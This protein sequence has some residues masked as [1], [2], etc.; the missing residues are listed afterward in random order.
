M[1]SVLDITIQLFKVIS[2]DIDTNDYNIIY[3]EL[4]YNTENLNTKNL[5]SLVYLINDILIKYN[6][7]HIYQYLYIIEKGIKILDPSLDLDR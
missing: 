1:Q 2:I 7:K 5:L 6:L 4:K 3:N